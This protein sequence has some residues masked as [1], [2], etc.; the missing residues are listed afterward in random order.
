MKFL[1]W[2]IGI[3]KSRIKNSPR[4]PNGT[5]S[6][7]IEHYFRL[8]FIGA[9]FATECPIRKGGPDLSCR[10]R[11]GRVRNGRADR[12]PPPTDCWPIA[13]GC[14]ILT[15]SEFVEPKFFVGLDDLGFHRR[16]LLHLRLA[17]KGVDSISRRTGDNR[18]SLCPDE[19]VADVSHRFCNHVRR[20][21]A[22][23]TGILKG[24]RT[25]RPRIPQ[26]ATRGRAAPRSNHPFGS[27]LVPA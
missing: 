14:G 15:S 17:A 21:L 24:A 11:A 19:R 2:L 5:N 13:Q 18:C 20:L 3:K 22:G 25:A 9:E 1:P 7:G 23:K 16:W 27:A 26:K 10:W 12:M 4:C 8:F 6:T